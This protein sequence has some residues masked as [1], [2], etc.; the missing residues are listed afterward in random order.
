MELR[1]SLGRIAPERDAKWE[2]QNHEY[3]EDLWLG[4]SN[5]ASK[6]FIQFPNNWDLLSGRGPPQ[7][8]VHDMITQLHPIRHKGCTN[9][10]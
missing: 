3:H 9:H 4:W 5:S 1:F 2:P 7:V 8:P 10:G 6:D